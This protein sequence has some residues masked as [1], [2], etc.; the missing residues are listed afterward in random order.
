[1][2]EA[3]VEHRVTFLSLNH[4]LDVAPLLNDDLAH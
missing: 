1:M 2:D 3:N 4:S